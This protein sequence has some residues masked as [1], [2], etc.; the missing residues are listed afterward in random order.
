[1]ATL[2]LVSIH[3]RK[4]AVL[5]CTVKLFL[6]VLTNKI[7]P[8][9][10]KVTKMLDCTLTVLCYSPSHACGSPAEARMEADL[11]TKGRAKAGDPNLLVRCFSIFRLEVERATRVSLSACH[12]ISVIVLHCKLTFRQL[13]RC[14]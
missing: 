1:M 2:V 3:S 9:F 5:G 8:H 11:T 12:G 7:L 10:L 4:E 13:Q 6:Y 14:R